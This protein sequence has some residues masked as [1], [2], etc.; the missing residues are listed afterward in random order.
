MDFDVLQTRVTHHL[1][2]G[3]D[4]EAIS[5]LKDNLNDYQHV[6]EFWIFY[7]ACHLNLEQWDDA[8]ATARTALTLNPE[9]PVAGE[10]LA[11]ALSSLHRR[12]EAL[13]VI[14][15]V[16]TVAPE[17][18]RG[19]YLLGMILL[20]HVQNN[21]ERILARQATEHALKLDPENPDFYQGA[22]LAADLADDQ[23][24]AL[25][26]LEAG[27]RI[28]PHHQGLLRAAGS[29]KNGHKVVGDQGVL[30]RG[31]LASDPMNEKLHGDYAE[32][33]LEKQVVYADRW[34][35]FTPILAVIA[36]FGYGGGSLGKIV[37]IAL[38]LVGAGVFAWWNISTY[39]KTAKSLPSG[40]LKDIHSRFPTLP[41]AVR[42][43]QGSWVV[44]VGGALAGCFVPLAGAILMILS[45]VASRVA[46]TL[47]RRENSAPPTDRTDPEERRVHLV[48][49]S[50]GFAAG[51]WKR[52]LLVIAH[53][54]LFGVAVSQT[55]HMATVPLAS[56]GLELLVIGG[57]LA[58]CQFRLG[59]KNNAFAYGLAVGAS[60]KSRNFALLR[61]NIGGM[62]FI[63]LHLVIG[64]IAFSAALSLLVQSPESIGATD[65]SV[66]EQPSGKVEEPSQTPTIPTQIP[67]VKPE[68]FSI[69]PLPEL[70]DLPSLDQ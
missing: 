37:V 59:F 36:A 47:I 15:Q 3:R 58:Y 16:I 40:Y 69:T 41:K 30:L 57:V 48:R 62:Y 2:T 8:E 61:G 32:N 51:F 14:Q 46:A 10:Q 50:G 5:L 23:N 12:D 63:G 35:L 49:L 17:Y 60:A 45:I 27:L 28:D 4:A 31:M 43:L 21:D 9:H 44:A 67:S 54:I 20:G 25:G 56:V 64:L 42:A 70:P 68:D 26:F 1:A 6:A 38:V 29:I 18:A 55:N 13:A 34:W 19:H 24:S 65:N 33:F 39:K 11:V 22:A 53:L 52:V 7:T 66:D